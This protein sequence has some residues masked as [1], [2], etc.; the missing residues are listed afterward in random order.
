[1]SSDY[2]LK[3]SGRKLE[4]PISEDVR[5]ILT[6]TEVKVKELFDGILKKVKDI[7]DNE[8]QNYKKYSAEELTKV[9]SILQ[10]YS[11]KILKLSEE[12]L[13]RLTTF[14]NELQT[15][16]TTHEDFQNFISYL[17]AKIVDTKK[18]TED[19]IKNIQANIK[20]PTLGKNLGTMVETNSQKIRTVLDDLYAAVKVRFFLSCIYVCMYFKQTFYLVE[21]RCRRYK[22]T[23]EVSL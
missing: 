7:N 19:V 9:K 1:M 10:E 12:T 20:E 23:C 5:N 13:K 22:T 17:E 8:L 6:V 3:I 2:E 11:I 21:F 4:A 16:I 15:K 18:V 14:K